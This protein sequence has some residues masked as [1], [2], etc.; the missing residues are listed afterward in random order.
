MM[1]SV[2]TECFQEKNTLRARTSERTDSTFSSR[3]AH[4]GKHFALVGGS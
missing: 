3:C 4:S 2:G 1:V